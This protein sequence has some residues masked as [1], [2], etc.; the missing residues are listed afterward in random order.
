M[1]GALFATPFV[2]LFLHFTVKTQQVCA[3]Y[4][5]CVQNN[6]QMKHVFTPAR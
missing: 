4:S 5:K 2:Q 6:N 1:L 3:E